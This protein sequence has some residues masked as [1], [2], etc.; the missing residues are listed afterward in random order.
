M[1]PTRGQ[2]D[3]PGTNSPKTNPYWPYKGQNT[4]F[5]VSIGLAAFDQSNT[6]TKVST[7][8][9]VCPGAGFHR[10]KTQGKQKCYPRIL[11][12]HSFQSILIYDI[13]Y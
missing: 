8:Y 10:N 13:I 7:V 11:S 4:H 5:Y 9:G 6:D 3:G 12:N 2:S 1:A